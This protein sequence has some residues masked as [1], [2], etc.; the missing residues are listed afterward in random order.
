MNKKILH[1][2]CG[3]KRIAQTTKGF[4]DGSWPE[5]RLDI[6]PK[7]KP[8]IIGTMLDMSKVQTCTVQ[9][10]FSSHNIEH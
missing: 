6:D 3:H 4:N 8:D 10:I 7:V 9:G 5:I 2:G 1:V